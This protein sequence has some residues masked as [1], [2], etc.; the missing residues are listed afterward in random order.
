MA[1]PPPPDRPA[2]PAHAARLLALRQARG[3]S[4]ADMAQALG[5]WGANGAD[6]LR[7]MERGARPLPGT[8]QLLM[9]T[10]ERELDQRSDDPRYSMMRHQASAILKQAQHDPAG[11]VDSLQKWAEPKP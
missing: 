11:F 8:L 5:L 7:Q 2:D 3:L 10:M 4:V 6:N 1:T 9:A